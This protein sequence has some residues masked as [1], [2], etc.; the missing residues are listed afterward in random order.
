MSI[1]GSRLTFDKSLDQAFAF[2]ARFAQALRLY[3]LHEHADS[4]ALQE[5]GT[6]G[7]DPYRLR[8]LDVAGYELDSPMA[9]Y[10]A[11]PVLYGWGYNYH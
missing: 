3:G 4:I 2:N 7:T 11:V 9:L 5:T 1:D 8:N 10:G 6:N